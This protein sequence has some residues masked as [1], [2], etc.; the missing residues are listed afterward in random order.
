[1]FGKTPPP[2]PTAVADQLDHAK[3]YAL[4]FDEDARNMLKDMGF[5]P[6]D[7]T[8][9][10]LAPLRN[11]FAKAYPMERQIMATNAEEAERLARGT[12]RRADKMTRELLDEL[13][14]MVAHVRTLADDMRAK[15]LKYRNWN[16]GPL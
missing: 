7:L 9:G 16:G 15:N 2:P 1:M 14:A 6:S 8:S 11:L 3:R 13:D 12:E 4:T 5:D 10:D